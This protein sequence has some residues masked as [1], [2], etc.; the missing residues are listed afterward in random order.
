MSRPTKPTPLRRD[1]GFAPRDY[2]DGRSPGDWQSR[3]EDPRAKKR[4][5]LEAGFLLV[6]LLILNLGILLTWL[7][8]LQ[9]WLGITSANEV[10]TFSL[11]VIGVCSGALGG[12][13]F[14]MK[15]LYH[16]V[17]KHIWNEDRTLWRSFTPLISGGLSFAVLAMINSQL[18][19]IF[20]SRLT[21]SIPRS[22]AVAF[23]VGFFSDN[24]IAKLAEIAES[25]F[26]TT[27]PKPV[28][29]PK[30]SSSTKSLPTQNSTEDLSQSQN[31]KSE[32][33]EKRI[34]NPR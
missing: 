22:A 20:D 14:S 24:T 28:E 21:A 30:R 4:I 2:S 11:Y 19:G 6:V 13:L 31:G 33:S 32:E 16:S 9:R 34:I 15:W 27:R 7:R 8:V 10:R 23:L 12:T 26:G 5:R 18:F 25:I 17:A 29:T 1:S 3:F